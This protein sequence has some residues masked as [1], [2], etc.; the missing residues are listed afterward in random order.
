MQV[1]ENNMTITVLGSGYV[2]LVTAVVFAELGN[3]VIGVDID[4]ERIRRLCAGESPIYEPGLDALLYANLAAGRLRF[5]TDTGAAV[6]ASEFIF[7][8]VGTPS[9]SDGSTD[10]SQVESAVR[11]IAAA[12]PAH[13]IVVDKST[14]P[15]GTGARVAHLLRAHAAPGVT[16]DVVSNPEFLREGTAVE[17]ALHPDRVVIGAD[18]PRAAEQLAALYRP[19]QAPIL[20]TDLPSAE[21]IKY[22]SNTFLAVKISF[23]NALADLCETVGA[24][25]H[26]VTAGVGAD[27][28]IGRQFL[29]AG[30]GYGGSCLPKDV[31]SLI[32]F[33]REVG[34]R[35][36]LFEAVR[37]V[38]QLRVPHL[39]ERIAAIIGPL[40][41]KTVALLG[42]TFK[43]NTDDLRES[44]A[45][46][47]CRQLLAAGAQ[48]RAHDPIAMHAVARLLPAAT[49]CAT[50]LDAAHGAQA[51]IIATEWAEYTTLDLPALRAVMHG[52][53]LADGRN[54]LNPTQVEQAGLRYLGIGRRRGIDRD[55]LTSRVKSR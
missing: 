51:V 19:L 55:G 6:A 42:L 26:H 33:S 22:A 13:R 5:T 18:N 21:M 52:D 39:I 49:Y 9:A 37:E 14:V 41:G 46:E 34:C 8:A 4:E 31:D 17:D 43:P 44:R 38:N 11:A 12:A 50:P 53:L 45:L 16:F 1:S 23:A 29:N 2:G 25:I 3:Q 7:I 27:P 35:S 47:L 15:V 32:A 40:T 36:G 30:I 54:C 10:L 48:V 24:D 28:R 20:L